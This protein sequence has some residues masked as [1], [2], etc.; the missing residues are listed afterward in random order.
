MALNLLLR[1]M[2]ALFAIYFLVLT[3]P[4]SDLSWL[5]ARLRVPS[6]FIELASLTY[7]FIFVLAE[8]A[9]NTY[10]A[11]NSRLGYSTWKNTF[12][13]LGK[14]SANV[15]IKSWHRS[16][17]MHNALISRCYDGEIKVLE[18]HFHFSPKNWIFT[19]MAAVLFATIAH[20]FP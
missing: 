6:L 5:L 4:F 15:L 16:Q 12:N 19:T 13:S 10:I 2:S 11:Q 14:L 8:T 17:M 3:T 18:R 7:R 1:S 9:A 20:L